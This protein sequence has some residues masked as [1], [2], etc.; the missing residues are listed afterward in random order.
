MSLVLHLPEDVLWLFL[1]FSPSVDPPYSTTDG[2]LD[3]MTILVTNTTMRLSLSFVE[4][5]LVGSSGMHETR[6]TLSMEQR[7]ADQLFSTVGMQNMNPELMI[8]RRVT[9]LL[10]FIIVPIFSASP[11]V[12]LI[13]HYS[14]YPFN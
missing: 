5:I 3:Q 6:I 13:L 10:G 8:R 1:F 11:S 2:I 14:D 12:N 4:R 7:R 9:D